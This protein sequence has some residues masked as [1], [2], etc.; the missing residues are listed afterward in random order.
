MEALGDLDM[1]RFTRR[2]PPVLDTL[3]KNILDILYIYERDRVDEGEPE[4][5]PS[6]PRESMSSNEGEG[7]GEAQGDGAGESSEEEGDGDEQTQASGQGGGGDEIDGEDNVDEFDVG[8]DGDESG[9]EALE[10][11]K[12]KNKEMVQQLMDDFK[13][14]WEPAV[15]KLDKAAK[16]FEGLDLDDLADGPEG[17]D[18]TR[19]LWQQTG[20]K[21]LDSLR[22]KL[23]DL[24]ELRDMCEVSAEGPVEARFVARRVSASVKGSPWDSCEARWNRNK[25]LDCVDRT[26]CLA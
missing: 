20:W 7:E 19:G 15:D 2:F 22:K 23:Q 25:P 10:N 21:E 3:M 1:A 4:M 13:E 9:S 26:I 8:M 5:P 6:E 17:F 16:A 14:Q 18:L 11:A 24:R 12:E